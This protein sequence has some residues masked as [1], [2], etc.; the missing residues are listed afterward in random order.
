MP[1]DHIF[2]NNQNYSNGKQN[3]Y[4]SSSDYPKDHLIWKTIFTARR[5]IC[6]AKL[7]LSF[8]GISDFIMAYVLLGKGMR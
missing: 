5:G 2:M 6:K 8:L 1:T 4:A 3:Q 7:S